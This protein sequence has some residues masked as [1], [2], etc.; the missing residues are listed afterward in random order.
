MS[1]ASSERTRGAPVAMGARAALVAAAAA[2]V[3]A[4]HGA[5][6][7]H[8][9][10]GGSGGRAGAL[11]HGRRAA[12][13]AGVAGKTANCTDWL[14]C[15][16]AG[17][18]AQWRASVVAEG[19]K[20]V[21]SNGLV[22]RTFV[23]APNW[24]TS[25]LTLTPTSRAASPPTPA[26]VP[27]TF[28][29][30][31]APEAQ[32][33]LSDTP[34]ASVGSLVN[35]GGVIGQSRYV[36]A[37]PNFP[38]YADPNAMQYA[39][40]T[41][42][43]PAAQWAW[44][45][46]RYSE[47]APWPPRGVHLAVTFVPPLPPSG[48]A[49]FFKYT[50]QTLGCNVA[51]C[52]AP[53]WPTCNTTSVPGQCSWPAGVALT[54]CQ[55][56]AA[57]AGLNCEAD[58]DDCQAR[59]G[60]S[61]FGEG[62]A[63]AY[64]RYVPFPFSTLTATVHY[65]MYDGMPVVVKWLEVSAAEPSDLPQPV[66]ASAALEVLHVPWQLRNRLH[67]E[68]D[69][70]PGQGVRYGQEATG[71][72]P[73]SGDW[74]ANFS[75]LTT[76]GNLWVYDTAL[77][78]PWGADDA[79]EYWYDM[80]MNETL[81]S[82]AFPFGPAVT[83][84]PTVPPYN[85]TFTTYRAYELLQDT[86]DLERSTLGRR[87]MLRALAPQVTEATGPMYRPDTDDPAALAAAM[88]QAAALG[89]EMFHLG[90]LDPTNFTAP[91]LAALRALV[92]YGH[93]RGLMM[94]FYTL[95]QNPPNMPTDQQAMDP[96]TG[97][98]QG[99]A[100]FATDFHAAFRANISAFV[101]AV[102]FDFIDTD[103]PYEQAACGATNHTYHTNAY[104][105][106]YAQWYQNVAW[107]R[108]LPNMT[109]PRS[110]LGYGLQITAPDPYELSSGQTS[111]PL[112]YT[113]AWTQLTDVW[114]SL[115]TMHVYMHDGTLWKPPPNAYITLQV[116]GL[117][118]QTDP[119]TA[120]ATLAALDWGLASIITAV[121]RYVEGDL[122]DTPA[123]AALFTTWSTLF[124]TYRAILAADIIHL[125]KATGTSW[126]A[127]LHADARA[128]PGTACGFASFFNPTTT[129]AILPPAYAV[130]MYYTGVARGASVSLTW[131]NGTS[132]VSAA[133]DL[134][135]NLPLPGLSIPPRGYVWLAITCT[136]A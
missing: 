92:D 115:T 85:G 23:V 135:F 83:V 123:A 21:M 48:G 15:D 28:L 56:W 77:M 4:G 112:G 71:W 61:V 108:T 103:G 13:A 125:R 8:H 6:G 130:P 127:Y 93:A 109:N 70:M 104:D 132:G 33:W 5:P 41:V 20:V 133:T 39:S 16:T 79:L 11:R 44:S 1:E 40:H 75:S 67:V 37:Y 72:Y 36:I 24:Y 107:Y 32:L 102:G 47:D 119:A 14:V 134:D 91:N 69:Y 17:W 96:V 53:V 43:S 62:N 19:G 22:S 86:D 124:D 100:C 121:G 29:R 42:S 78:G 73:A 89:F 60:D 55:E 50:S 82:V 118:N 131:S 54:A 117:G 68:T 80:G 120:N 136:P 129:P 98:P 110:I 87:R 3:A 10:H 57:C 12:A 58:R 106:Q 7:H 59:G 95:L 26:G 114:E 34:G 25:D 65:E 105:S 51:G 128:P 52:L 99:I 81:L 45:P 35:V 9:D 63:T 88:D 111:E 90:V 101:A 30:G 18:S 38:I 49:A 97:E 94:A 2:A 31:I 122:A 116:P 126:H 76:T 84:S 74:S 64:W 66:V 27:S 113:D 46:R